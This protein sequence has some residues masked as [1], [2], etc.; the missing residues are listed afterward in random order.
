MSILIKTSGTVY[1]LNEF[2][3]EKGYTVK[4]ERV[5]GGGTI[6]IYYKDKL[7]FSRAKARH[8]PEENEVLQ[9]IEEEKKKENQEQEKEKEK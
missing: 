8:Y 9:L 3:T 1:W 4:K 5:F 2:L 6:D 7:I